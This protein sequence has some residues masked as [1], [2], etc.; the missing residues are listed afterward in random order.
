MEFL[1]P[2]LVSAFRW[3]GNTGLGTG[4]AHAQSA[5]ATNSDREGACLCKC[6]VGFASCW[7]SC[8]RPYIARYMTN[9]DEPNI[10][11]HLGLDITSEAPDDPGA[12]KLEPPPLSRALRVHT[13]VTV[14]SAHSI[15]LTSKT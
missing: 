5:S 9:H 10:L 4:V 14:L 6:R 1:V 3:S 13:V 12:V 7:V 11:I 8:C 15:A 2:V